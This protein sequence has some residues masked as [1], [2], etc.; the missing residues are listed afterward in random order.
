MSGWLASKSIHNKHSVV[1]LENTLEF[2]D[3]TTYEQVYFKNYGTGAIAAFD[4][5]N[6]MVRNLNS[7]V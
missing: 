2:V 6:K 1:I 5:N 3:G 7:R 4:K